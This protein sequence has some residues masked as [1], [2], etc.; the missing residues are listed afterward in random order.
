M[1]PLRDDA[2][3]ATTPFIT[4][5]LLALNIVVFLFEVMLDT[6]ARQAF[7][8]QFGFLPAHLTHFLA[9]TGR[10]DASGA[11][12]PV[13]TSMFLHASWLHLIANMWALWI[14][15]DNV[16]D[17]VGHFKF[18]LLYLAAGVAASLLH[19]AFNLDSRIPSV[20]ASGAIA[21][22]MGAYFLLF[23]SARVLTLVPFIFVFFTWLPAWIVL[24]YW[25]VVQF[26]SGAAGAIATSEQTS[27][28]G[29]A[30]WAHVGGFVAGVALI[31]L[32]PSRAR[33]Y[34]FTEY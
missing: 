19:A 15:G 33:R 29:V 12:L 1:I 11:L 26:L 23:P 21:G 31:K 6:G 27:G 14:F 2:P 3:H 13:F 18:L 7:I 16:E 17:H 4:Y 10:V 32:L 8:Y 28:G 22:V 20:G 30:F 34:R 25:F 5:L 24:G 9:G